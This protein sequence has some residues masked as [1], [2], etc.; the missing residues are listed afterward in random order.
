M[1][2]VT[3]FRNKN[4]KIYRFTLEGH[5][6]YAESGEDIVCSAATTTAMT[7]INGLTDVVGIELSPVVEEGFID[8]LLTSELEGKMRREA[9]VLLESMVLTFQNLE[10]LYGAHVRVSE[11]NEN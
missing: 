3:F 11:Q 8:C 6:G 9:D 5:A 2:K 1:I 10:L 4:Q 7:V